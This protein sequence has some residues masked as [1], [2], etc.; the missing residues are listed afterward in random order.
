MN[1]RQYLRQWLRA[2]TIQERKLLGPVARERNRYI[3]SAANQYRQHHAVPNH[4]H[5]NHRQAVAGILEAHYK[6]VA[7]I[8]G[9]LAVQPVKARKKR[10][11]TKALPRNVFQSAMLEWA[12]SKSLQAAQSISDT[13]QDDVQDIIGK[14][15]EDGLGIEEIASDIA[16]LTGL[17]NYRAATIA[18][19]ETHAAATYGAIEE[20]R[21][22]SQEIG[23]Q[24]V[25]E[26][27]PTLDDRT[28]PDHAAMADY[29]PI[30]L[31]EKF[32]VGDSEM[33]RPGD[34][35]APADQLINCRCSLSIVEAEQ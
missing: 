8:F 19:T 34:P 22:T 1:R 31:D 17:T 16:D 6:E 24:L 11:E 18:R 27:L 33:D 2:L 29:G 28:R 32:Q 21:Q 12:Y 23:I 25:K 13:D 5:Q 26:W 9:S 35:S 15:L 4:V 7:P 10:M 14:G 30:P 3:K 20:A